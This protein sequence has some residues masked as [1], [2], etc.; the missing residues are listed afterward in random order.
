MDFQ[1]AREKRAQN[2]QIRLASIR[3][4]ASTNPESADDRVEATLALL[5]M[6]VVAEDEND[7]AELL[8]LAM[9]M[10]EDDIER[11]T[12]FA[13]DLDFELAMRAIFGD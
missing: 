13:R 9:V 12:D 5:G 10:T 6:W 3:T 2:E 7:F 1:L 8:T 11:V 4:L